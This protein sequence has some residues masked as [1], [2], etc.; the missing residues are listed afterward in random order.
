[1]ARSRIGQDATNHRMVAPQ[2]AERHLRL[3]WTGT[4]AVVTVLVASACVASTTPSTTT[5]PSGVSST[6]LAGNTTTTLDPALGQALPV[7]PDVRTGVLDNDLTYYIRFNDSPGERVELKL[8]VNVGSQQED[9][10]QSGS[11]HFLEHMMFNGTERFPRNEL[12]AV[13]ESFG[14]RFGPDINA[15]TSFDETVYELSLSADDELITLGIDVLREWAGEATLTERDVIEERG[16]VLDEWRTR[17][18]G[19]TGR[20]GDAFQELILPGTGYEGRLPIGDPE[21]IETTTREQLRR[22]YLDWYRPELMAVVAVGDFD[23]DEMEDR[24]RRAFS[25]L[26]SP[27]NPRRFDPEAYEPPTETRASGLADEEAASASVTVLWPSDPS[28]METVGDYQLSVALSMA[29]DI[30]ANRLNDDALRGVAPLLGSSAIEFNYGRAIRMAG[31]DARTRPQDL[32]DALKL[33][34]VEIERLKEFGIT[35]EEFGRALARFGAASEQLHEQQESAQDAS[36]ADQI[37]A[38]HLAGAHLMSPDQRFEVESG[39]L[40][41]L[42]KTEIEAALT[43]VVRTLPIILAVGPD[44]LNAVVPDSD[45]ILQ[46][47]DEVA[48]AEILVRED[49][50]SDVDVLMATPDPVPV[51]TSEVDDTFGYTTLTFD[52]GATVFLWSSDIAEET[53]LLAAESFGGTSRIEIEDL[54]EAFLITDIIGRSGVGPADVPTLQRLL[55]DRLVGVFPW[56]SETREGLTG[57]AAIKDVEV[58]FQ[59]VHLYM[60]APRIDDIAVAAVLDEMSTLNASRDDL[61]D[62]VFQEALDNGY[63]GEDPRYFGIPTADQ[64]A[65][66]DV[67]I[68]EAVYRE[69]FGNAGDFAFAFVG[70]FDVGLMT[71]LAARYVG[72]LPGSPGREGFVDNQPLPPREIQVETVEAGRDPQGRIAMTF[73]NEFEPSQKD[74]LNARILTFIVN[75]R[76]RNRIREELSATY[77]IIAGIDLQRD[78]DPFSESFISVTGDPDDLARISD[79]VIADLGDLL[80]N[81]PTDSQFATALEQLRTELD[82]IGNGTIADALITNYLYPDQPVIE[83][84]LRYQLLDEL[85][86][87]DVTTLAR[88]VFNPDQRIEV[89]LVPRS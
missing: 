14:P 9:D 25:D 31:V 69:R 89:R 5:L 60:T 16:V 76:L 1:M 46:L 44:D 45:R 38:H 48:S 82:L 15:H 43:S 27:D 64:L 2:K 78:P 28:P 12:I 37:V 8:L 74:R 85:T 84:R 3:R 88:I 66:F 67:A 24:I 10:D 29:L 26:E 39:V 36:F 75:G 87:A 17:S 72:T 20:I 71:D 70:D 79:E 55:A 41:R 32:E 62:V 58:L 42:T 86:A 83:L 40:D 19:F 11:A 51:L 52:N 49:T 33:V 13:L 4:I 65:D 7:D 47:M 80:E 68:A 18:Q 54:P 53:V 63:Y 21:S 81:G 57:S 50:A 6:T 56:I 34:L 35:E 23:V 22:F 77:S 59:L 61:P 30:V 73:T